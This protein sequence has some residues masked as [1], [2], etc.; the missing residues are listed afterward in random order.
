MGHTLR[1]SGS[2]HLEA[3]RV[4]VFQSDLKTGRCAVRMVHVTS[5]RRLCRVE[6]EDRRIDATDYIEPF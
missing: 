1:S 6:A 5:S 2:L 4:R 3:S